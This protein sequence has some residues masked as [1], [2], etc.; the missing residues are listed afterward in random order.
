MQ[1]VQGAHSEAS[2]ATAIHGVSESFVK[3]DLPNTAKEN[4][5][6]GDK[7]GNSSTTTAPS[8]RAAELRA[9]LLAI[10]SASGATPT[11]E[12]KANKDVRPKEADKIGIGSGG[13]SKAET[14]AD[15]KLG[16]GGAGL[17]SKTD[18]NKKD[19]STELFNRRDS[20][21]D[22]EGLFAEARAA[23]E[24]EK[25]I[26]DEDKR[27]VNGGKRP[28]ISPTKKAP[29]RVTE[30][31][32]RPSL[33]NS[34]ESFEAS[35]QGEIREDPDNLGQTRQPKEMGNSEKPSIQ[36]KVIELGKSRQ[37]KA[38]TGNSTQPKKYI[39]TDLANGLRDRPSPDSARARPG[40]ISSRTASADHQSQPKAS[41]QRPKEERLTHAER[42]YRPDREIHVSPQDNERERERKAAEYKKELESRRQRSADTRAFADRETEEPRRSRQFDPSTTNRHA[43]EPQ[44]AREHPIEDIKDLEDW[45]QMTGY[46]DHTYRKKA[47]ER[48][49]KLI[50]LEAQKAELERE[51]QLDYEERAQIAR[52]Q[53]VLPRDSIEGDTPRVVISP[54]TIRTSS[55]ATMPPP[56]VPIKQDGGNVGL[57]IKDLA[58]RESFSSGRRIEDDLRSSKRIETM[59]PIERS[60][61]KR[62]HVPDDREHEEIRPADKLAR[63][64][65]NGRVALRG[66]AGP[67]SLPLRAS[68]VSL[69]RRITW[70]DNPF[71]EFAHMDIDVDGH[72]RPVRGRPV[73]PYR[74]ADRQR[75]RSMSPVPRRTSGQDTYAT[76]RRVSDEVMT[77]RIGRS[78]RQPISSRESSPARRTYDGR[79][80]YQSLP[81]DEFRDNPP[82]RKAY[83][84]KFKAEHP[85][86]ATSEY[87]EYVPSRPTYEHHQYASTSGRARGRGRGGYFST[88][89]GYKSYRGGEEQDGDNF[90]TQSLNLRAGGQYRN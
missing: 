60:T 63:M 72:S 29:E 79:D 88:R 82:T 62:H 74:G 6:P 5:K 34:V 51:A 50:A 66:D 75:L 89:G 32:R 86:R 11:P 4:R 26:E 3:K 33:N 20:E 65:T 78:P 45:L 85:F 61:L 24:A 23:V 76:G 18:T 59:S 77:D 52:A 83:E 64:D 10:R 54:R 21:A 67:N 49:R 40:S 55:V 56:P 70:D 57:R 12:L 19:K 87:Q 80:T 30:S 7:T 36:G 22:I 16:A 47:L 17:T 41:I 31:E 81:Y 14:K 25:T 90:G 15:Q 69:E 68:S 53:S 48:H 9:K 73:S 8:D 38:I 27:E 46:Y 35:E 43:K 44:L 58:A 28:S 37:P 39:D 1:G 84:K 2:A 13:K 71:K 42:S